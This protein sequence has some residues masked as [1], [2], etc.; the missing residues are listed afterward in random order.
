MSSGLEDSAQNPPVAL[1]DLTAEERLASALQRR[2]LGLK[3]Y[4]DQEKI[5]ET[6]IP[7]HIDVRKLVLDRDEAKRRAAPII[8]I[9]VPLA[10][11][12]VDHGIELFVRCW[13][14]RQTT[15]EKVASLFLYLHIVEMLDAISA[16]ASESA[17]RPA[18]MQLR[19]IFEAL[20]EIEY[21]AE[22]HSEH[23]ARAFLISDVRRGIEALQMFDPLTPEGKRFAERKARDAMMHDAPIAEPPDRIRKIGGL[24]SALATPNWKPINDELDKAKGRKGRAEWYQVTGDKSDPLKG[25]KNLSE[26]AAHLNRQGQYELLYRVWSGTTHAVD[27]LGGRIARDQTGQSIVRSLRDPRDIAEIISFAVLFAARATD[28]VKKR[29]RPGEERSHRNWYHE[30]VQPSLVRLMEVSGIEPP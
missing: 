17:G 10:N 22:R 1:E 3:L 12:V 27:A 9:A 25:P 15:D 21:I 23:R 5:L 4:P 24:K 8:Q 7:S 13:R 6:E 2:A 19:S 26:L 20:L 30:K 18:R 29:L 16:L 14:D 11:E 28:I